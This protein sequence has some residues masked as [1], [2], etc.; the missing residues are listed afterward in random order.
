MS[1]T[2][3]LVIS[4]NAFSSSNNM[5]KTLAA[6]FNVFKESEVAQLYFY[7]YNPD[8]NCCSSWYQMTDFDAIKSV[9]NRKK[10]GKVRSIDSNYDVRNNSF[11]DKVYKYGKNHSTLKLLIRDFIWKIGNWKT[12]DLHDWVESI[13]PSCIFF[14]PGY[15]MFAY[16]VALYISNRYNI[17][18]ATYFCDDYYNEKIKTLSPFYWFR[19][20]L[21]RRKVAE[22]VRRS[23]ELIFISKSMEVEYKRIFDKQGHTIMTPFS[24]C[25]NSIKEIKKPIV[26]SYIGNVLLGRWKV[27]AKIAQAINNINSKETR[28]IFEVYSGNANAKIIDSLTINGVNY[29]KG[30]LSPLEVTNKI[31]ESDVLLH[32]ESFEKEFIAKTRHSISTKIAESLASG[33]AILGIGPRGIASID[34]LMENNAAYIIDN[35][36]DIEKKLVEYFINNEIDDEIISNA[37]KLA[38][39]NHSIKLN[40]GKLKFLLENIN[41]NIVC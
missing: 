32:V 8:V 21:F 27:L 28:I 29:Y 17:P 6:L 10:C 1:K 22:L 37:K 16:D 24:N 26:I 3:I 5:G 30:T 19:R 25:I 20:L 23:K 31:M 34:Y 14:A 2:K 40:S 15:S 9:I 33:R 38:K 35:E 4:H 12:K 18:I 41:E 7:S 39:K 36:S 11:K 13:N